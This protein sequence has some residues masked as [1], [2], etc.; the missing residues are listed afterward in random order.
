MP[1]IS[2]DKLEESSKWLRDELTLRKSSFS[3]GPDLSGQKKCN[4]L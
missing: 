4:V 1:R 3:R 2:Q